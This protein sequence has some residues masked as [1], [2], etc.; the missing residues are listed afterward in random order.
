MKHSVQTIVQILLPKLYKHLHLAQAKKT[1]RTRETWQIFTP[2]E[3]RSHRIS[4]LGQKFTPIGERPRYYCNRRAQVFAPVYPGI[5][6]GER[7][8]F[9]PNIQSRSRVAGGAAYWGEGG[10]VEWGF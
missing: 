2:R 5:A 10:A 9:R 6:R 4:K 8:N 3:A 1:Y 7:A